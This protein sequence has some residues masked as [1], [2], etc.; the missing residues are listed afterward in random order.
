MQKGFTL[1]EVLCALAISSLAL[2]YLTQSLTGSQRAAQRLDDQLNASIIAHAILGQQRQKPISASRVESGE[3][4]K[5][6]WEL[7]VAPAGI[8]GIA[9]PGRTL[10]RVGVRMFW[11]RGGTLELETVSLG[12]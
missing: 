6:R 7:T 4:G 3:Q 10:Y 2:V 9:P 8:A 1:V 5:F 12:R 11:D